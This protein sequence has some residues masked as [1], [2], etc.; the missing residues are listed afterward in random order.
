MVQVEFVLAW[1]QSRTARLRS[2]PDRGDGVQWAVVVGIGVAIAV[3]VGAIL[4]AKATGISNN[5][6]IQ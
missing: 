6:K 2:E 5:V 4:L 1:L 3:A